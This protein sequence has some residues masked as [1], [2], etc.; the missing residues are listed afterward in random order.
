MLSDCDTEWERPD[1]VLGTRGR[2]PTA[3]GGRLLQVCRYGYGL[4][5]KLFFP[6]ASPVKGCHSWFSID[7]HLL[8]CLLYTP[9]LSPQQMSSLTTSIHLLLGIPVLSFLVPPSSASFSQYIHHLSSIG[10]TYI[11]KPPQS[12]LSCFLSNR[13]TCAVPLMYSFL[14]SSI[15]SLFLNYIILL[16]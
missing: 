13:P 9:S 6:L 4:N 14:I 3:G 2:G 5:I 1:Q 15:I 16:R 8:D 12:C 11:F 10:P 7:L